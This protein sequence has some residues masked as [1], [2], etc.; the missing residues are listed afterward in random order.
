[1]RVK[2]VRVCVFAVASEV[3]SLFKTLFL[4]AVRLWKRR[5]EEKKVSPSHSNITG[6][7]SLNIINE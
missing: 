4:Q 3:E 2:Y 5:E 7:G 1:M 6:F